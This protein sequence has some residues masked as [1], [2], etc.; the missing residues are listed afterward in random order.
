MHGEGGR[1]KQNLSW[2]M[3]GRKG[4][5]YRL[6][7]VCA[8]YVQYCEFFVQNLNCIPLGNSWTKKLKRHQSRNVVCTDIFVWDGV[9]IL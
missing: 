9:A 2:K 6:K 5:V 4:A 8:C 3:E 7:N 1:A